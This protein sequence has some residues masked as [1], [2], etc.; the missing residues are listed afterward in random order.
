V[1][2]EKGRI[3][4]TRTDLE[5]REKV[6]EL[7]E[8]LGGHARSLVLVARELRG[9]RKLG[10]TTTDVRQIMD[11]LHKKFPSDREQ[12]LFA[13]VE[14]SLRKLP[15]DL[16]AKLPS[17]GVF[18]GGG[19]VV[20]IAMVLGLD[21][22]K[23][24]E[25][26]L[27]RAL[28]DVGLAEMQGYNYLRL[29]PA[30]GPF[31]LRE[32]DDPARAAAEAR[33]AEAMRLLTGFLYGQRTS[34]PRMAATLTLFEL[35]NLLAALEWQARSAEESA[36]EIA[37]VI[38]QANSVEHL[39]QSLGRPRAMQRAVAVRE[40]AAAALKESGWSH[41]R[42]LAESSALDRLI[43][44]GRAAEAVPFARRMLAEATAAGEA[45][46]DVAA[47]DLAMC[48]VRL[49]RAMERSGDARSALGPLDEARARFQ[50]LA[51]AGD[52]SATRMVPVCMAGRAD[53]LMALGRLDDAAEAYE[54]RINICDVQGDPRGA[55]VARFQIG[56]ARLLQRRYGDAIKAY[57][58]ARQT[59]EALGE[60]G[61]V[62]RA[63]HQMGIAL[64]AAQQYDQAETAYLNARRIKVELV[65][66]PDEASTLNEL[67]SLYGAMGR[68]EDAVR[69][70][71]EAAAIYADPAV[72]DLGNEGRIRNN[73]ANSL[74]KL[75]RLEEA[76]REV[77]RAIVC[78]QPFGHAV[79]PWTSFEIL[80][81]IERD[82]GRPDAAR[83]AR[84]R[85]FEA[86][87]A[88]RCDGGENQSGRITAR[89]CT[90]LLAAVRE[91]QAAAFVEALNELEARPNKPGYLIPVLA[92]LGA[93]LAGNRDPALADDPAL[94]Y[95][96]AAEILL[97]LER[98]KEARL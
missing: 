2:G 76:R 54:Q 64:H 29:D 14:L 73:A 96:D 82:A 25:I 44:A 13:S 65:D 80:S 28:I 62:A 74:Q 78:K 98:L 61:S 77:E 47:Y 48:H 69:F 37:S 11:D 67:G 56:T 8:V 70:Y 49:G 4:G 20:N 35:P 10:D 86:F 26:S 31:L 34:D 81:D 33:W 89:L 41:A 91:G 21:T 85:A 27:A 63:W 60:P 36:V 40:R 6:E 92:A 18:H 90:S 22:Q 52:E 17:L 66:R 71:R 23:D 38:D 9:G 12:S 1:L 53:A 97:L 58:E 30:L 72:G 7:A 32:L 88:Y 57:D 45:A 75:G 42:Y 83:A 43:D 39:L 19:H 84:G 24:E 3:A 79:E 5:S 46:Y 93:I 51:D 95:S 16:R 59:F 55:A 94:S 15:V 68:L 87:L 50:R